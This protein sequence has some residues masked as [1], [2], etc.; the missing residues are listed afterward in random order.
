MRPSDNI[1]CGLN[2]LYIKDEFRLIGP[3]DSWNGTCAEE[4]VSLQA[5]I[6]AEVA[7]AGRDGE[8][9]DQCRDD[10]N[11]VKVIQN[12]WGGARCTQAT[13]A[14]TMTKTYW[15]AT[16]MSS[17]QMFFNTHM[18]T[19]NIDVISTEVLPRRAS[20]FIPCIACSR[21]STK[22]EKLLNA[23]EQRNTCT[24]QTGKKMALKWSQYVWQCCR[25]QQ[26]LCNEVWNCL[27]GI[28]RRLGQ[29]C[30]ALLFDS[31]LQMPAANTFCPRMPSLKPTSVRLLYSSNRKTEWYT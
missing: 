4:S 29:P 30:G 20:L 8:C 21:D 23:W 7:A 17:K 28:A 2:L 27:W 24:H 10:V 6:E 19:N 26:P 16:H 22:D 13:H 12:K 3:S 31:S 15:H 25:E 14:C 5:D 1:A 9:N 18:W 11:S